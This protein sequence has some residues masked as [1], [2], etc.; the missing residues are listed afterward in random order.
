MV[1]WCVLPIDEQETRA[2]GRLL[3]GARTDPC[4]AG[5]VLGM[6][7]KRSHGQ[8]AQVHNALT[9]SNRGVSNLGILHEP[10]R[11]NSAYRFVLLGLAA[12]SQQ[13]VLP[14]SKTETLGWVT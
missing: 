1:G 9:H 5:F 13:I 10:T 7:S 14:T 8:P 12:Q 3:E 11:A 6:Q 4:W 2:G